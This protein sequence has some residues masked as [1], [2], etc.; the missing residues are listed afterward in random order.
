M[1]ADITLKY[2]G[3]NSQAC[4]NSIDDTY[5]EKRQNAHGARLGE[6]F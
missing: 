4:F 5:R 2:V 1:D 6:R 3:G